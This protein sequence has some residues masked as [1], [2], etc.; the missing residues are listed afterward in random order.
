[1]VLRARDVSVS[2]S[3]WLGLGRNDERNLQSRA[4][5]RGYILTDTV[6]K[7]IWVTNKQGN[8]YLHH[9][10]P[11]ARLDGIFAELLQKWQ[12]CQKVVDIRPGVPKEGGAARVK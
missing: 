6:E 5:F 9:F 11:V 1:M 7:L 8:S 3:P 4:A 10:S 12:H 2:C